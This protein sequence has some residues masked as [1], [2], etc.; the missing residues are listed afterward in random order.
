MYTNEAISVFSAVWHAGGRVGR[1]AGR[2]AGKSLRFG[3]VHAILLLR[4]LTAGIMVL[5]FIMLLPYRVNKTPKD[6]FWVL[7]RVFK[8]FCGI[9]CS[10]FDSSLHKVNFRVFRLT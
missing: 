6:V 8:L 3:T 1:Q 4:F 10:E 2:Q 9:V 5:D 7:Y